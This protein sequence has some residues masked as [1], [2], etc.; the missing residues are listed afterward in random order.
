VFVINGGRDRLYPTSIV[1]P[2]TFLLMRNGVK[3]D[4]HPQPEGEHNTA[5][6]P[7]MKGPFEEFVSSH[8]R[9]PYPDV[10]T[11]T[12]SGTEHNRAHWLIID[13]LGSRAN[14]PAR[15]KDVNQ[16]TAREVLF[17]KQKASGRVDLVRNGNTVEAV[18]KGVKAFTLL[19]S[20]EEFDFRQPVKVTVNGR[21]AFEG[22]VE[23]SVKT[24]LKWAAQDNDRTILFG[25]ELNIA[26]PNR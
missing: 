1:E 25:A 8:P 16:A 26:V 22:R 3:I 12:A 6:W 7:E 24:L 13:E 23:R 18:T 17:D 20:P 2:Y 15:L 21:A 10:L 4:Y 19:L 14:D 9:D 5:W 11:W